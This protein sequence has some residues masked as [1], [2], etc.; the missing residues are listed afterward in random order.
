VFAQRNKLEDGQVTIDIVEDIPDSSLKLGDSLSRGNDF[1]KLT[2]FRKVTA[3]LFDGSTSLGTEECHGAYQSKPFGF[4][5]NR[6]AV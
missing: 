3:L 5:A 4:E 6:A 1:I 2:K